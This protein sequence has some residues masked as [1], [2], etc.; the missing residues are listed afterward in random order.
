MEFTT[1][2]AKTVF[3]LIRTVNPYAYLLLLSLILPIF[4][5]TLK[6]AFG[7][8]EKKGDS[9]L[10]ISKKTYN[11]VI[12]TI[13]S[14]ISLKGDK[15]DKV[16]FYIC[17]FAFLIGGIVVKIGEYKEETLRQKTIALTKFFEGRNLTFMQTSYLN[18][19]IP[20][21]TLEDIC[22]NYPN[23]FIK[24]SD[25]NIMCVDTIVTKKI[26]K[27]VYP[28]LES[29]L[30]VKLKNNCKIAIDTIGIGGGGYGNVRGFFMVDII[31][32]FLTQPCNQGKYDV[33]VIDG[34]TIIYLRDT[35]K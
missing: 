20:E 19:I 2:Q 29:Y 27:T 13:V 15:A 9:D 6:K 17:I 30:R 35:I 4:W 12:S 10:P 5:I 33:D 32:G 34:R 25:S 24:T 1:E 31:Y 8:S 14:T 21:S 26:T 18:E 22:Y 28:L 3:D 11:R 16:V 23:A 7:I